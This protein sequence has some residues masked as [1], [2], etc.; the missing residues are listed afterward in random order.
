MVKCGFCGQHFNDD[1]QR[2]E[3]RKEKHE[4][5]HIVKLGK[6]RDTR[7][8]KTTSNYVRNIQIGKVVWLND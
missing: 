8:Y 7:Y 1:D 2:I 4:I 6:N 5:Y 3:E